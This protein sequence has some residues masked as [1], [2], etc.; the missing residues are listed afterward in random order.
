[1]GLLDSCNHR[2]EARGNANT[3]P[4]ILPG[5]LRQTLHGIGPVLVLFFFSLRAPARICQRPPHLVH[6]HL[7]GGQH[8]VERLGAVEPRVGQDSLDGQPLLWLHLQ[9]PTGS[10]WWWAGDQCEGMRWEDKRKWK[11]SHT[12]RCRM[13]EMNGAQRRRNRNSDRKHIPPDMQTEVVPQVK[14]CCYSELRCA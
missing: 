8:I 9:K 1:M 6:H 12:R 5:S 13:S 10:R 14:Q 4:V 11:D 3:Q 7:G 2:L